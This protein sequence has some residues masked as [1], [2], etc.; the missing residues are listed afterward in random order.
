MKERCTLFILLLLATVMLTTCGSALKKGEHAPHWFDHYK[1]F[2]EKEYVEFFHQ[3]VNAITDS[4]IEHSLVVKEFYQQR[5]SLPL[6]T[7]NGYQ[8]QLADTLLSYLKRLPEHGIPYEYLHFNDIESQLQR[9]KEHQCPNDKS[10]YDTLL[11]LELMLTDAYLRYAQA[12][13]YGA[14]DPK[15]ANGGKWLYETVY[16]DS[17]FYAKTL[18]E[19][20]NLSKAL[21][22]LQPQDANYKI[23]Q[24]ELKRLQSLT[25]TAFTPIPKVVVRYGQSS[26]ILPLVAERLRITGELAN[27]TLAHNTLDETL[28]AAIHK[29]STNNAIPTGDSLGLEV[30]DKLN[31]PI[32][33]YIDKLAVN[34]ERLRWKTATMKDR[35]YI[36]VNIPDF[37]LT[38]FVDDTVAFHTRVCCGKTQNPKAD[39][40]RTRKGITRAF[41]AE[42]PLLHSNIGRLVLNPEW[43]VPYGIIKDEYYYK[44]CKSNTACINRERMYIK[45]VRTG[46]QVVPSTIDWT[47]VSQNNIPYRLVQSS[48]RHNALGRIKF[49]FPNGESVYLHDTNNKG[50]FNRRVRALSHGCVRV[51]NPFDLAKVIYDLNG[52]DTLQQE[53]YSIIVGNAPTSEKGQEYADKRA[54]NEQKYY[55]GLSDYGK[56]FYRSVRPTSI[57]LKTKMPLF[58]EYFTCFVDHDGKLQYREDIYYKDQNIVELMGQ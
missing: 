36:A 44:L 53:Q 55:E 3:Q 22:D 34:M 57:G 45:D 12:L 32:A 47:A 20:E 49:D 30:I 31:R 56:Q 50:A 14:T 43:N 23:L 24:K 11:H 33:Y 7:N 1:Q 28:M 40:S 27:D 35:T 18:A 46:K 58:I 51:E 42:T 13:Q 5:E 2:H 15:V 52:Y 4:T 54:E 25:D 17:T 48:G 29:F 21:Q 26:D 41:K 37:T 19:T 38:A 10:I 39:P 9:L 8:A 6:W 16:A